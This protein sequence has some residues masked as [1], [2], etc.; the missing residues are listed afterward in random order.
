IVPE[1]FTTGFNYSNFS[2]LAEYRNESETIK[3]LEEISEEYSTGIAGSIL[4]KES[5][6]SED[7]DYLNIGFII[8]PTKGLSYTYQ[9]VNLWGEEKKHF[10]SGAKIP[11]PINFLNKAKV[12]LLICYDMRFSE[13]YLQQVINGVEILITT[14]AWPSARVN[15]FNLL[16]KARALENTTYHIAVN[17]IGIEKDLI[18]TTYPGSSRVIDPLGKILV[19]AKK[20]EQLINTKLTNK[21]LQEARDKIPVLVDRQK[22]I[23]NY[24]INQI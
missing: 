12:G 22:R 14:A 4:M 16:A 5:K 11:K 19:K 15:H 10:K 3:Q 9:K 13:I 6:N 2:E 23:K 18:E 20:K 8:E 17:R 7:K 21:N 1:L 24:E